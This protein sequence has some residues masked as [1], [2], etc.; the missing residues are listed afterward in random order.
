MKLILITTFGKVAA[1]KASI[2]KSK[3]FLYTNNEQAEKQ[4]ASQENNTVSALLSLLLDHS[5]QECF[6]EKQYHSQ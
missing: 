4:L 1:Y 6:S 5:V 2:Q 3:A